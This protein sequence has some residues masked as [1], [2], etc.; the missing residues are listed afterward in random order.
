[1]AGVE[2]K[3]TSDQKEQL[4]QIRQRKAQLLQT[5]QTE[6]YDRLKQLIEVMGGDKLN[7]IGGLSQRGLH[8][9]FDMF[10]DMSYEEAMQYADEDIGAAQDGVSRESND[11]L[12]AFFEKSQFKAKS[13]IEEAIHR[14]APK[15]DN[16]PKYV[17]KIGK[18][19]EAAR[20]LLQ[21]KRDGI[22]QG[23][24]QEKAYFAKLM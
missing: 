12:E 3:L 5:L 7:E 15:K 13:D 8:T 20:K 11:W 10:E 21:A 18:A 2:R 6:D 9:V 4:K 24:E 19:E 23:P 14:A 16:R 17:K 1:M 22:I